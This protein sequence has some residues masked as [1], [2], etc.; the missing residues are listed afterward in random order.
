MGFLRFNDYLE[1][2]LRFFTLNVFTMEVHKDVY[3]FETIETY[4][5]QT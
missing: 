4:N 1:N 3:Y 5:T 2:P